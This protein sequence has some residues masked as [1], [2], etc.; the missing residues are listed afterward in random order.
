MSYTLKHTN[1]F[2]NR[3][4]VKNNIFGVT[5]SSKFIYDKEELKI[6]KNSPAMMSQAL[7]KVANQITEKTA[8]LVAN[9]NSDSSYTDG[10]HIVVGM[11]PMNEIKDINNGMDIMM[12]LA[13]HEAC[14]CAFTDFKDNTLYSEYQKL[15]IANWVR[16]IYEDECIEEMLG[17]RIP[18]WMYFLDKAKRHYFSVEKFNGNINRLLLSNSEIDIIQAMIMYMVRFPFKVEFP[19]EWIDVYGPMLD[20]IYEKAILGINN[21]N[22]DEFK[23]SPT[24]ITS[25]ATNITMAIISKYTGEIEKKLNHPMLGM[26]GN[27]TSE[28]DPNLKSNKVSGRNGLYMPNSSGRKKSS[29]VVS[30]MFDKAVKNIDK[31]TEGSN[32]ELILNTGGAKEI[33]AK[34][35][36]SEDKA[37]Y[38]L[39][40]SELKQEIAIAKKIIIPN[41]KK[42]DMTDDDFHRNGQ[43]IPSQLVQA[44]QGVNCVYRKKVTKNLDDVSPKYAFV[45]CI[46]E[47]GSMGGR[48][49]HKPGYSPESVATKLAIIF[50]EAMKDYKDIDLYVYGHGDDVVKYIAPNVMHPY[51]LAARNKQRDQNDAVAYD[52]ILTDV[53]LQ[54]NAPIFF[55]S[56]TD[57]LYMSA[58]DSIEK[59][60]KSW[61][62]KRTLFGLLS[63]NNNPI[64]PYNAI[65]KTIDI[66]SVCDKLYGDKYAEVELSKDGLI[67]ALTKF[68]NIIKSKVKPRYKYMSARM[69]L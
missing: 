45:L 67:Q 9:M 64:T 53:R 55:L 50:Y 33:G 57:S 69:S 2:P 10:K 24:K 26:V 68:A 28:G 16:N 15:P 14:H 42:I 36:T 7:I 12:G 34:K 20:E 51:R 40:K 1:W 65:G 22:S 11:A 54:T 49:G 62:K 44:I 56:I 48:P 4:K 43:I 18:N 25:I 41:S 6:Y 60:I 66:N 13:C 47:S 29:D 17:L 63:L 30:K 52:T 21:M 38:L 3:P 31:A 23:Y 35:P 37:K 27:S 32:N 58:I 61:E 8:Q 19:Q 46:D 5:P 39:A 59:T